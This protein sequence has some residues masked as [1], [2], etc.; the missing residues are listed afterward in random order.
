MKRA[1]RYLGTAAAL[2]S[3]GFLL[4]QCVR[5][6][7]DLRSLELGWAAALAALLTLALMTAGTVLYAIAWR[8]LL[9]AGRVEIPV[10]TAYLVQARSAIAKY[11]PGNVFQYLGRVALGKA[12]GIPAEA[13]IVSTA[14]ET[15]FVLFGAAALGSFSLLRLAVARPPAWLLPA[16]VAFAGAATVVLLVG[17]WRRAALAWAAANAS[18]F[19]PRRAGPVVLVT[20]V[21]LGTIGAG[22]ALLH[23][24]LWP[25]APQPGWFEFASAFSAAWLA[26]FIVPGAP[27][28]LGVREFAL[29][30]LLGPQLGAGPAAQLF[31][32]TRLLST[33]ADGLAFALTFPSREQVA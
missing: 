24:T 28:G 31:L 22:I 10:R 20:I 9:R 8:N 5:Y 12:H 21:E 32:F 19:S 11:L 17:R 14:A 18:Y 4:V 26:G 27:G 15:L 16:A 13:V 23:H 1:L 2:A 3:V 7:G 6:A 30:S 33:A 29:Y 25:L